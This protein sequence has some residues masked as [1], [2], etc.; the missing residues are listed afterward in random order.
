MKGKLYN[1]HAASAPYIKWKNPE[2]RISQKKILYIWDTSIPES[3]KNMSKTK[4]IP[5]IKVGQKNKNTLQFLEETQKYI[6]CITK[7]MIFE[8]HSK[9][10]EDRMDR[11]KL[12]KSLQIN[13]FIES[14]YKTE[15][16]SSQTCDRK[17]FFGKS[18]SKDQGLILLRKKIYKNTKKQK[19]E[20]IFSFK[21]RVKE[22]EE[23]VGKKK[24]DI[25][26]S[27]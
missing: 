2:I 11:K 8:E 4:K 10:N 27:F 15:H 9:L 20:T 13:P 6:S 17:V 25:F 14:F 22:K 5:M 24:F 21:G 7:P 23:V 18:F 12:P 26:S 1:P 16:L 19:S 3:W